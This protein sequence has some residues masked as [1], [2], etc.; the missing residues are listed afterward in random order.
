[1]DRDKITLDYTENQNTFDLINGQLVSQGRKDFTLPRN[2]KVT[3]YGLNYDLNKVQVNDIVEL[4]SINGEL[5]EVKIYS[6]NGYLEGIVEKVEDSKTTSAKKEITLKLN[7]G[8]KETYY[9]TDSYFSL[10]RVGDRVR[11]NVYYKLINKVSMGQSGQHMGRVYDITYSASRNGSSLFLDTSD[12]QRTEYRIKDTVKLN[13]DN[14]F[15]SSSLSLTDLANLRNKYVL[16]NVKEGYVDEITEITGVSNFF[17][18]R[19]R[20]LSAES[21]RNGLVRYEAERLDRNYVYRETMTF[22]LEKSA[23]DLIRGQ[24]YEIETFVDASG[25]PVGKTI[26]YRPED[27]S[28]TDW[29]YQQARELK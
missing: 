24:V 16:I 29:Y 18:G 10:P 6:P 22:Q 19:V 26:K 8:E 28:R 23:W 7:N 17:R 21:D 3:S 14:S 4:K 9:V 27:T 15:V 11:Y 20:I 12:G 2:V 5:K 1:M 13:K 25:N